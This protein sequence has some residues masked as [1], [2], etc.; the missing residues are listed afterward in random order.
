M[1]QKDCFRREG[2][3]PALPFEKMTLSEIYAAPAL[4]PLPQKLPRLVS[5]VTSQTPLEYK[6]PVAQ[7]SFP[8]LEI[9]PKHLSFRYLDNQPRELRISCLIIGPTG[10]GKD[11]CIRGPLKHILLDAQKRDAINRSRLAAFNAEF[12]SKSANSE[13]PQRPDDL[14]IQCIKSDITR[15]ALYQRM[16]EAKGAPLFVKMNELEQWDKVE[17][18]TGRN[19]QFTIIGVR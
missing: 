3:Q 10:S 6:A 8:A 7:A 19:N 1:E 14:V 13:K 4:P 18:A 9:Y 17:G 15:A 5:A 16:D 11:S 2:Q 12:N